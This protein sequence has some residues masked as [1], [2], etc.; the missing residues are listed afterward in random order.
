MVDGL[1]HCTRTRGP[2]TTTYQ[3]L[4][5]PKPQRAVCTVVSSA[6]ARV[7]HGVQKRK[8]K[9]HCRQ[10]HTGRRGVGASDQCP[11]VERPRQEDNVEG[12][13]SRPL[14]PVTRHR[15]GVTPLQYPYVRC[16][17]R[18]HVTRCGHVTL[19]DRGTAFTR[20][21]RHKDITL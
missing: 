21:G 6:W 17:R 14:S 8:T 11:V 16:P 13:W 10:V 20:A 18:V 4:P 1:C 7:N 15:T 9:G 19:R 2:G 3:R 12:L 5:L